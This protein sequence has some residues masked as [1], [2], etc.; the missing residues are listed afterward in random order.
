MGTPFTITWAPSITI[1]IPVQKITSIPFITKLNNPLSKSDFNGFAVCQSCHITATLQSYLCHI[2]AHSFNLE[3]KI[4][5][6]KLTLI[7]KKKKKKKK[8][9]KKKKKK[10]K[11]KK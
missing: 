3:F 6:I 4:L 1:S 9:H 2:L 5:K 8:K 7:K 11:K 10:K